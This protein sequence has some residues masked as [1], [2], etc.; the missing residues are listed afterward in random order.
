[1]GITLFVIVFLNFFSSRVAEA[2]SVLERTPNI[3]NGWIPGAVQFNFIHRMWTQ[4]IGPDTRLLASPSFLL[5]MPVLENGMLAIRYAPNST[6]VQAHEPEIFGRWLIAKPEGLSPVSL[7]INAA[8]NFAAESLD[9]DFS[10]TRPF[11]RISVLGTFRAF[12]N[13]YNSGNF[14]IAAGGGVIIHI[15]Q[16]LALSGDII[17]LVDGDEDLAWGA[18]LQMRVP[19]S[20]HTFSLQITNA[21]THTIHGSSVGQETI[22]YGFE[23]TMPMTFL[24]RGIQR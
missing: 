21:R 15:T 22:L 12:S 1:M 19:A 4:E 7:V 10:L 11:G 16:G 23:F 18:G 6:V 20:P 8:Y 13:A 5:G 17:S 2:Q 14:R 3:S 9:G 24:G